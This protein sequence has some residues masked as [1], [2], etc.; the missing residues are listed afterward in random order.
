MQTIWPF[1]TI[2]K[3]DENFKCLSNQLNS[4][5]KIYAQN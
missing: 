2:I 1:E 3:R 5:S 4:N